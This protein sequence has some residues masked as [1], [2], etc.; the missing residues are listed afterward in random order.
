MNTVRL[1]QLTLII[2]ATSNCFAQE[3]TTPAT[4]DTA[5]I[6]LLTGAKG[7]LADTE[8][9]FKVSSPR[10]DLSV[11][12]AGVKMTAAAGL[13]SWAA[14]SPIA[15]KV[16]VMGDMVLQEEQINPVMTTAL[17]NGLEVTALHNHFL[18]D[19]PKLM[20]MHIGGFGDTESLAT[21]IG[22]VFA[23]IKETTNI[24]AAKPVAFDAANTS[25]DPKLIET[26]IDN[27]LE[28]TGEVYKLTVG[29]TTTMH[30]HNV[31]KTMGVNTWAVFAGSNEHAI[32]AGDFA[33]LDSELQSVLK[34][35]RTAGISI[36]SI[37]NHM[38]SESPKIIFLHY[39]GSG[40]TIAL[41]KGLK[42][43]LD[44]HAKN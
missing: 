37:H 18:W 13:T 11:S 8:N 5:K 4:L 12:V 28:K 24:E 16:T 43:A 30:D 35:L 9:V 17:E 22:K 14:F 2:A 36:T 19:T 44:V 25:L 1:L 26:I 39:W 23:K 7:K 20:F 32:V 6:E 40:T 21:G 15:D 27:P 3:Q 34:A 38:A 41:A 33:V 29:R 31:G 10:S 42:T